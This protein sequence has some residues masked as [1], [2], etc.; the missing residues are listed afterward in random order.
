MVTYTN[1]Q[2]PTPAPSDN[3]GTNAGLII[4]AFVL[5]AAIVVGAIYFMNNPVQATN[6]STTIDRTVSRV[7]EVPVPTVTPSAPST[8]PDATTPD[9]TAPSTPAEPSTTT[10]TT[11]Q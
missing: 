7:E 3:S 9:T 4:V 1:N 10:T 6:T 11:P 5:I 8:T 2:A